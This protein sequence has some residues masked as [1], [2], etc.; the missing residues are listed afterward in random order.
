MPERAK[1]AS[2]TTAPAKSSPMRMPSS[3]AAG[4]R[5]LGR[6]CRSRIRNREAPLARAVRANSSCWARRI[7]VASSRAITAAPGSATAT[8]GMARYC[9]LIEGAESSPAWP[10]VGKRFRVTAS[11]KIM[12]MAE[13]NG[14]VDSAFV[15]TVSTMERTTR[16]DD[17]AAAVPSSSPR[18]T[19][20]TVAPSVS[21]TVAPRRC[22][23]SVAIGCRRASDCPGSPVSSP[24][25]QCQYCAGRAWSSPRSC[26]IAAICA[27]VASSPA[28]AVVGLPGATCSSE[29][30]T[31]EA[32]SRTST[33]VA[34]RRRTYRMDMSAPGWSGPEDGDALASPLGV[35]IEDPFAWDHSD[36]FGPA[37]VLPGQLGHQ[38]RVPS[39]QVG[40]L[41]PVVPDV[42][43][44][45]VPRVLADEL[46]I[47]AP[48]RRVA[49]VLPV[50][51]RVL[52]VAAAQCRERATPL[53]GE[54]RTVRVGDADRVEERGEHVGELER[55][56]D[57]PAAGQAPARPGHDQ[58]GRDAALVHP[59]RVETERSV[60]QVRPGLAVARVRVLRPR[61]DGGVVADPQ[62]GAVAGD[63]RDDV[64]LTAELLRIALG[65][66]LRA[67]AVVGQED[68]DR[69]V[70]D[71]AGRQLDEDAPDAAVHPLD[72]GGVHPH[73]ARLPVAVPGLGPRRLAG[74]AIRQRRLLTENAFVAKAAESL[75]PQ[76]VPAGLVHAVV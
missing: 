63:R 18:T 13:T 15:E 6:T 62:L 34:S 57:D 14:G 46:P 16:E 5:L 40:Q 74:V 37:G 2:T 67:G 26:W 7:S 64:P 30:I 41:R 10:P 39:G 71:A 23:T 25:S 12:T 11:T 1:I 45:P 3:T 76:L 75:F 52:R 72:L 32:T 54:H 59:P 43:E 38:L 50:Q 17:P 66:Y 49:D 27:G 68:D 58:G 65:Q 8:A 22:D 20:M 33:A 60:G 51:R 47:A 9:T 28:I 69:V 53:G 56:G 21:W 36:A 24:D 48:D 19:M 44:L 73:A 35:Q 29:K 70:Q 61:V 42:V 31:T 55:R 4:P